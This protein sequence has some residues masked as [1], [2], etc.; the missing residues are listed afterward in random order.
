MSDRFTS[1]IITGEENL[2]YELGYRYYSYVQ[3][4]G[5]KFGGHHLSLFGLLLL[6]YFGYGLNYLLPIF[7]LMIMVLGLVVLNITLSERTYYT[8]FLGIVGSIIVA[9]SSNENFIHPTQNP[10]SDPLRVIFYFLLILNLLLMVMYDTFTLQ[11]VNSKRVLTPASNLTRTSFQKFKQR[12]S[13][14]SYSID[15]STGDSF[16]LNRRYFYLQIQIMLFFIIGL[17]VINIVLWEV[18]Q[19]FFSQTN[20][21]ETYYIGSLTLIE[22]I[23]VLVILRLLSDRNSKFE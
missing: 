10:T 8:F 5:L 11:S 9:E 7:L 23:I 19:W 1:E 14:T 6:G 15:K 18:F 3:T 13:G 2:Y 12:L 20:L 17:F 16:L 22:F 4:G 21:R